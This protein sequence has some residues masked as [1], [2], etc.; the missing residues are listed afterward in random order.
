MQKKGKE[1]LWTCKHAHE[2]NL[3][4]KI[5]FNS[6]QPN[7]TLSTV[8]VTIKIQVVEDW[9]HPDVHEAII[10]AQNEESCA[11]TRDSNVIFLNFVGTN[12]TFIVS[13]HLD[14]QHPIP[15]Y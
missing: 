7:S 11:T 2:K 12:S 8:L 9:H 14:H 4:Q 15:A 6:P 3:Q 1:T 5:P 13:Y 10:I